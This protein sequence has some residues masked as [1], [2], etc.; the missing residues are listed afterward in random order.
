MS[1]NYDFIKTMVKEQLAPTPISAVTVSEA[2]DFDGD[3]ILRVQVV[4]GRKNS[5]LDPNKVLELGRLAWIKLSEAKTARFPIFNYV[6]A[7]DSP[8]APA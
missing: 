5:V 4:L 6:T 1:T 3:P 8:D 7:A 2:E